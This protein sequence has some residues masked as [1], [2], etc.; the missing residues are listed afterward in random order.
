MTRFVHLRVTYNDKTP[1]IGKNPQA[2]DAEQ[3]CLLSCSFLR[4]NQ[5]A[6]NLSVRHSLLKKISKLIVQNLMVRRNIWLACQS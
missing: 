3:W 6:A 4:S 2:F 5:M 1:K